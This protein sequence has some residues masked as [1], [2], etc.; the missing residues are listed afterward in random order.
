VHVPFC[1]SKCGYCDFYSIAASESDFEPFVDAV[2]TELASRLRARPFRI[3]TIFVGGG[4]PTCLPTALLDKLFQALGE[5]AR[6][7]GV[8]EFSVETN[9]GSLDDE[10]ADLLRA[11]G[12]NRISMGAQSFHEDE[13]AVL[14]RR[15]RPKDISASAARVHRAG[16]AHFNLDLIFG[17]PG[18]SPARWRESL[19][20]AIALR[21]DHL[22][23]YGL[24]YEPGTPL[25]ARR[26]QGRVRPLSE[27][28]EA[29]LYTTAVEVLAEAGFEQYEISNFARPG[30]RCRHN[31]RYWHNQPTLGVGPA[32]ASYID[33]RRWRNIPDVAAYVSRTR[34]GQS[35]EVDVERLSPL[36]RAGE[37]AML[38]LR[39][40]E[41]IDTGR[42]QLMTGFDAHD[43]FADAIRFHTRAGL[44]TAAPER[45]A[46]TPA[47]RLVADTVLADFVS[48]AP[49]R[50]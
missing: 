11:H 45:I 26:A 41:G 27:R 28:Q 6:T 40:V 43:L 36:Q 8:T 25:H 37:T 2:R 23:C 9:P 29:R 34:R 47:G 13:L 12:V 4:T 44:L 49:S 39:T 30:G 21:P 17:I 16:F 5:A 10:K 22:S 31:L 20:R 35:T 14:G 38:M 1:P 3:E 24:T 48:P 32:A 50:T 19:R 42:Y 46:L 33:G 18:Q 7:H 15:H